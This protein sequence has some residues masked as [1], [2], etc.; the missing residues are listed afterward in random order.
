MEFLTELKT[1]ATLEITIVELQWL[2]VLSEGW[3]HPL[4]GFM[5]EDEYLQVNYLSS[6]LTVQI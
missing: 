1:L 2:Q 4:K 5:R 6:Y 3:A